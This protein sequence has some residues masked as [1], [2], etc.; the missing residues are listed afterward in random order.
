M[1]DAENFSAQWIAQVSKQFN[2]ADKILVEKVIRALSLLSELKNKGLQFVF[3]GG[4]AVMI[5][6]RLPRRLSIDI[7]IILPEK[8]DLNSIFHK[9]IESSSFTDYEEQQRVVKGNI[10]KAHYKFKYTPTYKTINSEEFI[11]LDILYEHPPY[12][13][14][15]EIPVQSPFIKPAITP[16]MVV[17]PVSDNLL[18]DKLTAFAP[19]TTGIPYF[20]NGKS[21]S[22]EIIKQLFDIG[23]LVDKLN[24][25]ADVKAVFYAMAKT[26]LNYRR[27]TDKSP[28][29]VLDDVI[30][31]SLSISTRGIL[32]TANF[33]ELQNGI[34]RIKSFLLV[35]SY[36]IEDAIISASKAAYL[37]A[38]LK[39]GN[40]VFE[41]YSPALLLKDTL[42]NNSAFTKLNKLKKSNPEAFYYWYKAISIL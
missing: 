13:N 34:K 12:N 18:G 9:I 33:N 22:M 30:D 10:E 36:S 15:S 42:I 29:D 26:E 19:N 17:V 24:N 20:K 27:L 28:L 25:L 2:S 21:M 31:T 1:I 3:K 39:E 38:L 7:D 11:L 35:K 4:T 37:A 16:E 40:S 23:Y 14:Y 5:Q 32:G 8:K 41:L 6:S